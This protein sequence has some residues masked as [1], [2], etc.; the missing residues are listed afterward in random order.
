M[1]VS[2]VAL[3]V[4]AI[5]RR[6]ALPG[7]TVPIMRMARALCMRMWMLVRVVVALSLAHVRLGIVSVRAFDGS[8]LSH[9]RLAG[10]TGH[11]LRAQL[12]HFGVPLQV[13]LHREAATARRLFANVR[14]LASV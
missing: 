3:R 9:W 1:F 5:R 2:A 14:P 10:V 8:S 4:A 12:M 13:A 6:R 7:R 11:A